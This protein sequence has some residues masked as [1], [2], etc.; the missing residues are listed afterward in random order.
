[1]ARTVADEMS[2]EERRERLLKSCK[3]GADEEVFCIFSQVAHALDMDA[4]EKLRESDLTET[5][6]IYVPA[7]TDKSKVK[8]DGICQFNRKQLIEALE[9][10]IKKPVVGVT[11]PKTT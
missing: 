1:M 3:A 8:R 10:K 2:A 5:Q 6:E 4:A 7:G 9:A 11:S